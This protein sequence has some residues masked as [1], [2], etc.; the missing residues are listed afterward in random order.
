MCIPPL[1]DVYTYRSCLNKKQLTLAESGKML[2][3]DNV[4]TLYHMHFLTLE[5]WTCIS[6]PYSKIN[7]LN[8]QYQWGIF[9]STYPPTEKGPI[10]VPHN[11]FD[12]NHSLPCDFFYLS[13][14][15]LSSYLSSSASL[16]SLLTPN[17]VNTNIH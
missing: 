12:T 14:F 1:C 15:P 13:L 17:C 9:H 6:V 7:F 10:N 4:K 16:L 2:V 5:L 3:E 11:T 8:F